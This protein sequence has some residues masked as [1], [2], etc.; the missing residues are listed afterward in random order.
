[1]FQASFIFRPGKL[2]EEFH[3]IN[4][5][6]AEE[7]RGMDGYL[8]EESWSSPA[9]GLRLVNYF[10]RDREA[11]DAFVALASHRSAKREQARW[12]EGYHVIISE[13]VGTY[14]DGRLPHLT[15]DTRRSR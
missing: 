2:D 13:V 6:V 8:G 4:D 9:G 15:G 11:L 7:A 1:M 12:Y 14:G 5:T 10:W 3:R